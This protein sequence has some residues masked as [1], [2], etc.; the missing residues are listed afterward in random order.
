MTPLRIHPE[1]HSIRLQLTQ[2]RIL[3]L[4][5]PD[6]WL[7]LEPMLVIADYKKG[8]V[9]AHQ[10]DLEIDQH[11]VIDG[12]LKR[13]V[14]NREG[15]EMSLRFSAETD[16]EGASA[17]WQLRTPMPYS[18]RAVTKARTAHL[19]VQKWLEFIKTYPNIRE[20]FNLEVMHVMSDVLAH[21]ITQHL[22]DAPGRVHRFRRKQSELIDRLPQR[23]LAAHLNITPETL[24]R[25]KRK[26][27]I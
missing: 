2:N 20:A 25:L 8:D 14:A 10:G 19:P 4:L 5:E 27:K 15:K 9:L 6:Q 24:S 17:A 16:I 12:I 22:L 23:E 3:R 26:G 13:S 11:F 21:T 18:I 1:Y 7:V